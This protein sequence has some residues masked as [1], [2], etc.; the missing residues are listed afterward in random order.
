VARGDRIT[1]WTTPNIGL[2]TD[3]ISCPGA[4]FCTLANARSIPLAKSIAE[5]FEDLD[6]SARYR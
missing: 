4:E 1:K 5:R 6:Y 2:L 3:M